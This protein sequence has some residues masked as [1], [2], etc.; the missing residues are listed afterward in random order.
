VYS[1]FNQIM[2]KRNRETYMA[3]PTKKPKPKA[4]A[5]D[6]AAEV[7][8]RMQKKQAENPDSCPFC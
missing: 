7:L 6:D 8:A 3:T 4:S 5:A 1:T 2:Q